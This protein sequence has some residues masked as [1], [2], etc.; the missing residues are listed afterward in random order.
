MRSHLRRIFAAVDAV[1]E[2]HPEFFEAQD[3]L[4]AKVASATT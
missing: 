1:R 3:R 2:R 4:S